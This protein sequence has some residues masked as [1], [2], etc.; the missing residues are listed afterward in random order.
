MARISDY[1]GTHTGTLNISVGGFN[2][3]TGHFNPFSDFQV[4]FAGSYQFFGQTGNIAIAIKLTNPDPHETAGPC[5]V[6]INGTNDNTATYQ[7]NGAQ[8][9]I[10][11]ALNG[12]PMDIYVKDAGTQVDNISGHDLWIG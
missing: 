7:I 8:M 10:T 3:G 6:T 2:I 4:G 12:T 9:T 11:T 5:A 1:I